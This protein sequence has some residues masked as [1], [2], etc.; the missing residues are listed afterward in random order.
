MEIASKVSEKELEEIREEVKR[1]EEALEE[2]RIREKNMKMNLRE[3]E[4]AIPL[5]KSPQEAGNWRRRGGMRLRH[6]ASECRDPIQ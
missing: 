3:G 5:G 4:V 2:E 1:K 6:S